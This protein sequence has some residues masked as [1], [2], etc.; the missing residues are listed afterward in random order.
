MMQRHIVPRQYIIDTLCPFN[1]LETLRIKSVDSLPLLL[2]LWNSNLKT[3]D[4]V[5]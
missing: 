4:R 5:S 3:V 1:E 2:T